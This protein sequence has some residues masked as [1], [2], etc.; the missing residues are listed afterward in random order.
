MNKVL[1][2]VDM[3]R[4]FAAADPATV[5]A[6]LKQIELAKSKG[7]PVVVLEFPNEQMLRMVRAGAQQC[8]RPLPVPRT[9]V[10]FPTTLPPIMRAL[11]GH[12]HQ[13]REKYDSD[14]GLNVVYAC[15]DSGWPL[16]DFRVVGVNTDCCVLSTV[17]GLRECRTL[18]RIEVVKEACN[19]TNPEEI[20]SR[21]PQDVTIIP[22][23]A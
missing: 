11:Q 5:A 15:Y 19:T 22:A 12:P 18:A 8:G 13:V 23:A 3:Q 16:D 4:R 9:A 20:W 10:A 7:W 6:V 21:F 14:G 1:V 2:I 17:K